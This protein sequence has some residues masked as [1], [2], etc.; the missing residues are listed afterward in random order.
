MALLTQAG[1]STCQHDSALQG[2]PEQDPFQRIQ[3]PKGNTSLSLAIWTRSF[4]LSVLLPKIR[5][6]RFICQIVLPW[7]A[8][9]YLLL[10]HHLLASK[11]ARQFDLHA[12]QHALDPAR[13]EI[14]YSHDPWNDAKILAIFTGSMS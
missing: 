13:F 7:F 12:Q 5:S 2:R 11:V 3:A 8:F 1:L 14:D 6:I 4:I 9:K 10:Q